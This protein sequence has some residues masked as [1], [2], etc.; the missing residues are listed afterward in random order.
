M[1]VRD[2]RHNSP[3]IFSD[4]VFPEIPPFLAHPV[5]HEETS[6]RRALFWPLT[7]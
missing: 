5:R 7:H 3:Y 4:P 1:P 2:G 6:L